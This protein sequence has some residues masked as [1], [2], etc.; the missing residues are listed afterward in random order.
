MT[1][2]LDRRRE[3][4]LQKI[5][6]AWQKKN[7]S[8]LDRLEQVEPDTAKYIRDNFPNKNVVYLTTKQTREPT[9]PDLAMRV[10]ECAYTLCTEYLQENPEATHLE[11]MNIVSNHSEEMQSFASNQP[12]CFKAFTKPNN[13]LDPTKVGQMRTMLIDHAVNYR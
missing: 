13:V 5:H 12:Q 11:L 1:S 7:E 8:D 10:F 4:V 9:D 2:R 6:E 3:L